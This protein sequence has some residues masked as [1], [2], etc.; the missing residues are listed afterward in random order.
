M[1]VSQAAMRPLMTYAWPGNVRQLENAM[2]RAVALSGSRTQIEIGDLPPDIQQRVGRR[3]PDSPAWPC[4]TTALDFDVVHL[5]AS[6][7]K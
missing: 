6:S 7:T 2:E 5:D 4:P 3:R 1:T